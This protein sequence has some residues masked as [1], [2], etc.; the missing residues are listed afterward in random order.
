MLQTNHR[1][2]LRVNFVKYG[3]ITATNFQNQLAYIWEALSRA[4][5]IVLIMFIFTQLWTAVYEAQGAAEIAGLS[6]AS[7]IWYFLIAEVMELGKVRHDEHISQEVKDGTIA[8][9][10]IRP[11]SYLGY[12][13][14]N[15]LGETV[16]KMVMVFALGLPVVAYYAG[17]PAVA[18]LHLPAIGLV[19]L[20][21]IV[22]DFMAFSIIGLL[23]F[24][25]EDTGA[26]RLIY[27][28]LVFILGGL[29][30][31]LDF[32][33]EWLQR[34]ARL[35]PFQL[36]TYAPAKLFALFTWEQ[37]RAVLLA[38]FIWIAIIG[39]ILALQYRWATNHLEINGG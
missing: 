13:F 29:L 6:L 5:F 33:P 37:F 18:L 15:G 25:T 7:T 34:I 1:H 14:F 22:I 31:P 24:W 11:Y 2:A 35:L 27:Q 36:T 20:L 16:I 12:H 23:A 21:A 3:A 38:Q 30:I 8:Y 19:M 4:A 9:T 39:V 17:A 10:L 26:F 32:L 28:K